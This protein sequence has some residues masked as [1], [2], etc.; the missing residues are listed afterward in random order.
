MT[1]PA[2]T[3]AP[4]RIAVPFFLAHL[5][6]CLIGIVVLRTV[7]RFCAR[8]RVRWA[9]GIPVDGPVLLASNHRSYFDPPFAAIWRRGAVCY[10]AREDLWRNPLFA[11][12]LNIFHGIPVN[13]DKPAASSTAGAIQRLRAGLPVLVFP[14]GT[15]T[16]DGRLGRLRAGP[17]LMARRAR[18]PVI[19]V[20]LHRTEGFW[21]RGSALP[22]IAA[23][24]M[25]VRYGRPIV[26]PAHLPERW[27]DE[28]ITRYLQRWMERQEAE[29]LGGRRRS[30][31][32]RPV[33]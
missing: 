18:V 7:A 23:P 4:V 3:A 2:P 11:T 22:R 8:A 10:F 12:L 32:A 17:A 25:E 28:Y 21:P 13:R 33:R 24:P 29:L 16:R 1:V 19:P 30:Q 20:Y 31:P 5:M 6:H 9:R 14:E 26:A 27:Q 15:R